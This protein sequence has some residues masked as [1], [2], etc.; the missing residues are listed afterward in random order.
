MTRGRLSTAAKLCE[1]LD[2]TADAT[3]LDAP[4]MVQVAEGWNGQGTMDLNSFLKAG[5]RKAPGNSSQR[6]HPLSGNSG[7]KK[8]QKKVQKG[9]ASSG[10]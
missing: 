10:D 5:Q 1:K 4:R 8:V 9:G 6:T 7:L 3:L 2:V